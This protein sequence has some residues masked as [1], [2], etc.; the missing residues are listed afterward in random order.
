MCA[1]VQRFLIWFRNLFVGPVFIFCGHIGF[2]VQQSTFKVWIGSFE[3]RVS[4]IT[5]RIKN[6]VGEIRPF[7]KFG[8]YEFRRSREC[9]AAENGNPSECGA[10]EIGLP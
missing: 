9:G 5:G 7:I 3:F 10:V 4:E 2:A 8:F 1:T 6:G